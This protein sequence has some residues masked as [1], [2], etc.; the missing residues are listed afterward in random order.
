MTVFKKLQYILSSEQKKQLV[1][2]GG[3]LFIGML[4]EMA[5]LGILI[6]ALGVVLNPDIG[7]AYP[8]FKPYLKVMGDPTRMQFVFWGMLLLIFVYMLKG[9]FLVFLSWR[10]SKFSSE[11]S[12]NISK[13]LFLGYLKQPYSFHLQMNTSILLRNIQTEVSTFAIVN[14]AAIELTIELTV[15]LGIAFTLLLIEPIGSIVMISFLGVFSFLFHWLTRKRV[16]S[17]GKIRQHYNSFVNQH[18]LQGLG[19]VKDIKLTGKEIHFLNQYA[20][21][22]SEITKIQVKI[23]T[24]NFVPRMYLELLSVI[25]LAILVV[26]ML[27][28]NK[29]VESLLPTLGVFVAGAFRLLPSVNRIIISAQSMRFSKPVI[30][31]LYN[32][33]K[34]IQVNEHL[35]QP[36]SNEV[37]FKNE[38]VL[39]NVSFKFQNANTKALDNIS[40]TIREGEAVGF[41]GPSGSGKSTLLDIIL[42][43]LTPESGFIKVDGQ[44][45]QSNLRNWQDQIGYVPQVIY[46]T[47][48]SLKNN[49]AFGIPKAQI[50][51]A[52]VDRAIKAAQLDEFVA[53]LPEGLETFVGERGVRL[54]GGQ[55]QRLGIARAL[56]HDPS[57]LVLDEATSALDTITENGVMEAVNV[58]KGSKTLLIVA[59]R[60]STLE[61]C[62]KI[63]KLENGQL[64]N[65]S[66]IPLVL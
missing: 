31:L 39:E 57:V 32:E 35:I 46:L 28:Q 6:P 42:G 29:P 30:D 51:H 15:I 66:E 37:K 20:I 60:L 43:L 26:L 2:L 64:T 38:I 58:F 49:V 23:S 5:S 10:Q 41:M 48:D 59:H 47:D 21:Q 45:I 34:L 18:L 12:S 11:L 4:F 24:L 63:Y 1:V 62:N 19:A 9:V 65:K 16:L 7:K 52:A 56:Y 50:D 53:S 61:K 25:G 14:R 44:D 55:R 8:D 54:S 22:L 33:F 36:N 3:L 17:W 27:I 40:L 13:T